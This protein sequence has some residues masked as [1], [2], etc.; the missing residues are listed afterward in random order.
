MRLGG[1]ECLRGLGQLDMLRYLL[2]LLV[3][4]KLAKTWVGSTYIQRG[5]IGV[6]HV[7]GALNKG[8]VE[9]RGDDIA[10]DSC[11]VC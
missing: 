6:R 8:A 9:E 10:R 1:E 5:K 11:V 3:I 7:G 2:V 4:L